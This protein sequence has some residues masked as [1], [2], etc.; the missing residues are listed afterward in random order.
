MGIFI[1]GIAANIC[2]TMGW[3]FEI[4]AKAI[5]KERA[6]HV[7]EISF[8]LGTMFSIILTLVPALFG[9]L[10]LM[11]TLFKNLTHHA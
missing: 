11:L 3:V 10:F 2:Y 4:V 9:L 5:W 7:G 8:A 1:Y 6:T